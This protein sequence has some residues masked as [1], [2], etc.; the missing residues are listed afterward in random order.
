V[1]S[2]FSPPEVVELE[3]AGENVVYSEELRQHRPRAPGGDYIGEGKPAEWGV[4]YR[5]TP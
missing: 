3:A 4:G 5:N 1:G 2:F